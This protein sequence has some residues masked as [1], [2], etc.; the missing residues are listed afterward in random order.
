MANNLVIS[1]DLLSPGQN[2]DAVTDAVKSL[3]GVWAKIQQSV[4]YVKSP[5]DVDSAYSR[6][7]PNLDSNDSLFITDATNNESKWKA[8]LPD[9]S[10][11]IQDTWNK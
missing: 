5:H 2:Y 4:F 10:R 3:G 11:A 7:L 9:A 8:L 1:Y 6:I